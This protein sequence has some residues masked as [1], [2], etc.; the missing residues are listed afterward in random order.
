MADHAAMRLGRLPAGDVSAAVTMHRY[1]AI[2]PI[3]EPPSDIDWGLGLEGWPM[4]ANDRLGDCTIAGV[5]HYLQ[6]AERWRDGVG[7]RSID[8]EAIQ[9]YQRLGYDPARPETDAGARLMDVMA[10][11]RDSGF[12]FM[13]EEDKIKAFVHVD[14]HNKLHMR[15][16]L[17]LFGPLILGANM[18]LAAQSQDK[19]IAPTQLS[20]Q[21]MP[22]SWGGHCILLTAWHDDDTVDLITWG[23]VKQASVDWIETY[24]DESWAVLHPTWIASG[25]SPSGFETALLP[26]ELQELAS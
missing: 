21:D 7:R 25:C 26:G 23:E 9:N 3:G 11:W 22:G 8:A 2:A 15:Q 16:A 17:W 18:P 6:A 24:C 10:R 12:S 1:A 13:N 4:Y 14:P 20:D 19:W 5:L